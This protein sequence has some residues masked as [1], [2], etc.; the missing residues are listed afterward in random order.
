M[1]LIHAFSAIASLAFSVG[2]H[3]QG[4]LSLDD[5]P[6]IGEPLPA[7]DI[8]DA[9]GKSFNTSQIRGKH[10]VIVFGCLT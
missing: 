9:D 5:A 2:A 1:R 4:G 6:A 7:V 10:A 8:H 3:A